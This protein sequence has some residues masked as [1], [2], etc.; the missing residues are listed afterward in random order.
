MNASFSNL[1][2]WTLSM[3]YCL[4]IDPYNVL[5]ISIFLKFPSLPFFFL[6][7]FPVV[8]SIRN[9]VKEKY[10]DFLWNQKV[11]WEIS[12]VYFWKPPDEYLILGVYNSGYHLIVPP[13]FKD[14]TELSISVIP[15]RMKL[16]S[17]IEG[18]KARTICL[19]SKANL[20]SLL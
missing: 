15:T 6:N 11:T 7:V 17:K 1:R 19:N 8:A 14:I 5:L 9:Q 13:Y 12:A 18:I 10:P 3:L 16:Q 2:S 20:E 4:L